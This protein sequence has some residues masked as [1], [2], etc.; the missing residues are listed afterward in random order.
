MGVRPNFC[1]WRRLRSKKFLGANGISNPST[2]LT[3]Y[4][5]EEPLLSTSIAV[6]FGWWNEQGEKKLTVEK[7]KNW[8]ISFARAQILIHFS[9]ISFSLFTGKIDTRCFPSGQVLST[10]M[11]QISCTVAR[12]QIHRKSF[13]KLNR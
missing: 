3:V 6:G 4:F 10:A 2:K 12:H 5:G 7:K 11:R 1:H 8:K 9:S 13:L